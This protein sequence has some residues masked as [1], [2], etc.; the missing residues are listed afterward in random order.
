[1]TK[2]KAGRA[3][4]RPLNVGA[5]RC[6][7]IWPLHESDGVTGRLIAAQWDPWPFTEEVKCDIAHN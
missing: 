3:G 1:M 6:T 7:S 5:D 4:A 2:L